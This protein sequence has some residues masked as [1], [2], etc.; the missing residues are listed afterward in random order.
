MFAAI[1]RRWRLVTPLGLVALLSLVI[2]MGVLTT[3]ASAHKTHFAFAGDFAG[4]VDLTVNPAFIECFSGQLESDTAD[5]NSVVL[6]GGG[7]VQENLDSVDGLSVAHADVVEASVKSDHTNHEG[8]VITDVIDF[9]DTAI[10]G[11]DPVPNAAAAAGV[12]IGDVVTIKDANGKIIQQDGAEV[13]A[14]D[15]VRATA[16]AECETKK[17]HSHA[18]VQGASSFDDLDMEFGNGGVRELHPGPFLLGGGSV[19][20]VTQDEGGGTL[21]VIVN[22][23]VVNRSDD[24]ASISLNGLHFIEQTP[25]GHIDANLIMAHAFAQIHCHRGRFQFEDAIGA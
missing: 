24:F 9:G 15:F 11:D 20:F 3:P 13:T 4:L 1:L 25:D 18:S 2:S 23:S 21:I 22:E 14:G 10:F 5:I 7:C 19:Q 17:G 16:E 8:H 6:Q 12:A